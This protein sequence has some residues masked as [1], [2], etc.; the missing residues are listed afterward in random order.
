MHVSFSPTSSNFSLRFPSFLEKIEKKILRRLSL[1]PLPFTSLPPSSSYPLI[2]RQLKSLHHHSPV[3]R[4]PKTNQ[5]SSKPKETPQPLSH[6]S[7]N[8]QIRLPSFQHQSCY[9]NGWKTPKTSQRQPPEPMPAPLRTTEAEARAINTKPN[10][11]L[12]EPPRSPNR[13]LQLR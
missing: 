6:E 3:T 5:G 7:S 11:A 8:S 9:F 4:S 13:S 10:Q 12:I 2:H 1:P